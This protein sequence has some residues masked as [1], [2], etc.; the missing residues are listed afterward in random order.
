ML[1]VYNRKQ[2]WGQALINLDGAPTFW[3]KA[4][5]GLPE[6]LTGRSLKAKITSKSIASLVAW[7][8]WVVPITGS[9]FVH[10]HQ[11]LIIVLEGLWTNEILNFNLVTRLRFQE[12]LS[13]S[14]HGLR[15]LQFQEFALAAS[16]SDQ[17][18]ES[19]SAV[20]AAQV[21]FT[22]HRLEETLSKELQ[23]LEHQIP[24]PVPKVPKYDLVTKKY[25]NVSSWTK[26]RIWIN[27]F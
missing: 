8:G 27:N 11:R 16:F 13:T 26:Q 18:Q 2:P 12:L 5:H 17:I 4:A 25:L 21:C 1:V 24:L 23:Q 15:R 14:K 19:C 7:A 22:E 3:T 20:R 9:W 10:R 6:S